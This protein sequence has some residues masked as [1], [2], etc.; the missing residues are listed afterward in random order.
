MAWSKESR[1]SRGYGA[2]W[3][4]VRK[5]VVA[6]DL[7]LCQKCKRQGRVAIGREVDHIVPKAKAAALQWSQA[8]T[9]DPDNLEL[10]CTP[11]HEAKTA[12]DNGKAYRPKVRYGVDGWPVE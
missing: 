6:R 12:E 4:R 9:D 7:G 8:K 10:L 3:D 2:D 5:V 11:C 1:Q